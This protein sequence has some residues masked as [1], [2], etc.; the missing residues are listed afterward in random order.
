MEYPDSLAAVGARFAGVLI[1]NRPALEVMDQHDTP[2]TLHFVDPPY[3]HSTRVLGGRKAGYYRHEMT[4]DD[5]AVL[6]AALRELKG[7]VIITS[8]ASDL[9]ADALHDWRVESTQSRI[10]AARGSALRTEFLWMNKACANA[11]ESMHGGLFDVRNA[12]LSG[13]PWP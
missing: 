11:I 2:D 8:Y 4:D 7:M 6:L 12:G 9:Y 3:V 5:H 13:D 10:S 1:E